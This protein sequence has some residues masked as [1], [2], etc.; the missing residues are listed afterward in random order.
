MISCVK[1]NLCEIYLLLDIQNLHE[2]SEWHVHTH[3]IHFKV[4][5]AYMLLL[6]RIEMRFSQWQGWMAW[7][8][9]SFINI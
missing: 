6:A 9:L 7:A 4:N 3:D 5:A 2:Q 8:L 1:Y